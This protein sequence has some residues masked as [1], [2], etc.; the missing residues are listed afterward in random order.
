MSP[1]NWSSVEQHFQALCDLAPLAQRQALDALD[2]DVAVRG[3]LEALLAA[4]R[5]GSL[6]PF[7]GEVDRLSRDLDETHGAGRRVGAYCL[8]RRLGAGGMGEVYLARRAD[9]RY[10]SLVAIKFL[11]AAGTRGQ[12]L[13]D[14]ERQILAR[15]N[16]PAIAGIVDAGEDPHLG[17]YLVMAYVDGEPIT[18]RAERGKAS[19]QQRLS[20][21]VEACRAV[22][23]AHQNLILHRDLKPDHLLIDRDGQLKILDFGVAA[24]IEAEAGSAERTRQNSFTLRYAS[25]EQI[26]DLPT[27]TRTDVYGLGMVLFELISGGLGPFGEDPNRQVERKLAGDLCRL[28]RCRD[29]NIRQMKDLEA[30]IGCSLAREPEQRFSGPEEL[31]EELLAIV[32]DRPIA[33]RRPGGLE[34]GWRW[35]SRHQVLAT[36]LGMALLAIVGGSGFSTWFAHQAQQ[37]RR[38]ALQQAD[39]AQAVT[40]FLEE[41]FSRAT[42]GVQQGPDTLVR[43]LL[44]RGRLRIESEL[45]DQPDVAAYLELTMARSYLFLGL[46]AEALALLE[47]PRATSDPVT[48]NERIL[49]AARVDNLTAH[50]Q[51]A[52]E[53]MDGLDLRSLQPN[54]LA[55]AQLQRAVSL[56]NL[57]ELDQAAASASAAALAAD[58][59]DE[60]L[61]VRSNAHNLLGVIA[62]NRSDFNAARQAFDD[63][64]VVQIQRHGQ[65]HDAT[66]LALHNLGG[67][68]LMQG[69]L[70][71]ALD[72]YRRAGT[73]YAA[74]Y[75]VENRA[76]A[77]N[78]RSMGLTLRRMGHAE[79]AEE[80]LRQSVAAYEN[81][82]GREHP[83]GY[84][85]R[86]QLAELLLITGDPGAAAVLLS[87]A[88]PADSP[89]LAEE[90]QVLCRLARLQRYLLST[91][92]LHHCQPE[93]NLP[94]SAMAFE[95]YLTARQLKAHAD[96]DFQ[97]SRSLAQGL[98]AGL[99]VPDPLLLAAVD[100]L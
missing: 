46:Y 85:A 60:G 71:A 79:A 42:P 39:K 10:E 12:R 19:A 22:V 77:M 30:V 37:E 47:S 56:I 58:V 27:T 29:L 57:G 82:G 13:F 40:A 51:R 1:E 8:I 88:L 65:V 62:F 50:Y 32:V 15:L 44:E 7:V 91:D 92:S 52:L 3:E 69:D 90:R 67:V 96:P 72:Y 45:A 86:L 23:F 54:Q 17:A 68:A 5:S 2:L 98:L 94:D 59:G 11:A 20:W 25:P 41:V 55:T 18:V 34:R 87:A 63:Y 70:D 53:R 24:M 4:D 89:S 43:D 84:E 75:G 66:G 48:A 35:I 95:H 97:H 16:H 76:V 14:R 26:L 31:A 81:W 33:T 93:I 21:M 28:P 38:A 100:R 80:A 73:V 36:A 6:D 99:R 74:F 9:G 83:A 78:H 64:L 61:A 49:L